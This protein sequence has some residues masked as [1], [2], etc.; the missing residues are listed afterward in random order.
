MDIFG[1][2]TILITCLI[3]V[4]LE[5]I[6]PLRREQKALRD[7]W[8]NDLIFWLLNGL[9]VR[10]GLVAIVVGAMQLGATIVPS[11]LRQA[12]GDM[13]LWLQLPLVILISD[14]GVYWVHRAF[15]MV[16]WLWRF[17]AVHHSIEELDWLAAARFHPIDVI[18]TRAAGLIPIFCLGFSEAAISIYALLYHWQSVLLHSNLRVSF[19]P[20]SALI[21]SPQ[22]HHWHHSS[23]REARDKN[24]ASQLSFL[25][26]LF[27]SF[28]LPRG[29]FPERYGIDEPM[30][31]RFFRQLAYPFTRSGEHVAPDRTI[32][33]PA[34]S[35]DT[36]A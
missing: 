16:P 6:F 33:H 18:A 13:P 29:R 15:H 35:E 11:S 8:I 10:I 5:R 19:G 17:H 21:V 12:V 34:Q 30:T 3:F 26:L 1:F 14:L 2:K 36:V 27:G 28:H 31:Q 23:E 4:P 25:D 24:F 20:L 22:F 7:N 32:S 9:L